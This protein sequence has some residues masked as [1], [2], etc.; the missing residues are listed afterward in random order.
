MAWCCKANFKTN[1][2][3]QKG[4]LIHI[5]SNILTAKMTIKWTATTVCSKNIGSTM[6]GTIRSLRSSK[7]SGPIQFPQL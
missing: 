3:L 4:N 5:C 6:T 2:K 7:K 1:L